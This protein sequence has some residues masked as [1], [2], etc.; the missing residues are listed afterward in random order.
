[1][2]R[3]VEATTDEQGTV[4]L[5]EAVALTGPHRAL[6]SVSETGIR[7]QEGKVDG[8]ENNHP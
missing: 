7:F 4:R 8:L 5:Q 3:T 6:V 2:I 1:M